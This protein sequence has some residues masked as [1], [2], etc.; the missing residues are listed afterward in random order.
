MA[1]REGVGVRRT[2]D[3]M[4]GQEE[5]LC[6]A[7][8]AERWMGTGQE[9]SQDWTEDHVC[10]C[11][12]RHWVPCTQPLLCAKS[13]SWSSFPQTAVSNRVTTQASRRLHHQPAMEEQ[14]GDKSTLG[15]SSVLGTDRSQMYS[16]KGVGE[17]GKA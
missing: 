12:W 8:G 17:G 9:H 4:R 2:G 1:V 11:P 3:L 5:S 16:T 13:W 6:K 15:D 7:D 10:I 14:A